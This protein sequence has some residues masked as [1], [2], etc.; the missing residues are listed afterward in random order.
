M[1]GNFANAVR[2]ATVS[3]VSMYPDFNIRTWNGE[4]YAVMAFN[5]LTDDVLASPSR[6]LYVCLAMDR[7]DPSGDPARLCYGSSCV[8]ALIDPDLDCCPTSQVPEVA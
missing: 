4:T 2:T 3:G 7:N 8:Y 5:R 1:F 6:R